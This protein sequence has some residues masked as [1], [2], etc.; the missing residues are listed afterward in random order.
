MNSLQQIRWN[1]DGATSGY[2]QD[3]VW[4]LA[5]R[6]RRD[7]ELNKF[8]HILKKEG[9]CLVIVTDG[10]DIN[11]IFYLHRDQPSRFAKR[12]SVPGMGRGQRARSNRSHAEQA[13]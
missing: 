10:N 2:S 11:T 1:L 8:L 13:R 12:T 3:F 4:S 9:R 6:D 5:V 7:D